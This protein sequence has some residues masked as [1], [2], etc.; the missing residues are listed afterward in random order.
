MTR[1]YKDKYFIL[2]DIY[3]CFV[4]YSMY[5]ECL[6]SEVHFVFALNRTLNKCYSFVPTLHILSVK[7]STLSTMYNVDSYLDLGLQVGLNVRYCL[8]PWAP[9]TI[10]IINFMNLNK[11]TFALIYLKPVGIQM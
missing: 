6:K 1:N 5:N 11:K 4:K 7:C 9:P 2:K 10:I 3:C 8:V